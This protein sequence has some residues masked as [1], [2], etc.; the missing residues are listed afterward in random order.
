MTL[1]RAYSSKPYITVFIKTRLIL[2]MY[3]GIRGKKKGEFKGW[4]ICLFAP[5]GMERLGF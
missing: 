1:Y 4:H 3:K 5:L 2:K